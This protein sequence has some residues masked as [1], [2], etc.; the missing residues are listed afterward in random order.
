L[1]IDLRSILDPAHAAVITQEMQKGVL[2]E[3]PIFPML[4]EEARRQAIPNAARLVRAARSAGARVVHCIAMRRADGAGSNTNARI[5]G[6]ARKSSGS[7]EPRTEGAE[8]IDEIGLEKSD[9]VS[10][11]LHGIGP[12][13]GTDLD[14]M[15]RNLDVRTIVV[16]GASI[17]VGVTNAVMDAVNA[18]YQVVLPRDAVAGIPGD[19]ADAVID[20]TLSLL[21][22][23]CTTDDV[24]GAWT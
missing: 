18:G 9:L 12:M 14:S 7:I 10:S 13:W 3:N 20:N 15:L 6:A 23:V 21:A 16:V 2:G 17:N 24:I 19:Y 5:F 8:V 11:R 4:A 22:T 1:P